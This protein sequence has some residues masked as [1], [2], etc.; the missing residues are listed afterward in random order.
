MTLGKSDL[1]DNNL[2]LT[3]RN[4]PDGCDSL[5]QQTECICIKY[6]KIFRA[7]EGSSQMQ[8]LKT[9]DYHPV[10]SISEIYPKKKTI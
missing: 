7:N 5:V 2:S 6:L 3:P 4:Y 8:D 9:D 10:I 1:K